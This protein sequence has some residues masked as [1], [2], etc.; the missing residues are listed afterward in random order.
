MVILCDS[1]EQAP[2]EFNH[3]YITGVKVMKLNVGD[4]QCQFSDGYIPPISIERK[5][6]EDAFGTLTQGY[7]RFRKEIIRARENKIM[8]VIAIEASITK[9]LKGC[10]PS[11]RSGDEILQQLMS[12][13]VKYGVPFYCFNNRVEMQRWIIELFLAV[14]RR[15]VEKKK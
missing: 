7:P 15:Y 1:R 2:L 12:I 9:I 5:S 13:N 10:E 14:G 6:L 11:I 4:Y 8:L 3:Q